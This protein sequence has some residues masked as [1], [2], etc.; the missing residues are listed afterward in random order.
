MIEKTEK[1]KIGGKFRAEFSMGQ[2]H[3]E[4]YHKLLMAADNLA[5]RCHNF[6]SESVIPFYGVLKQ[7]YKNFRP[8]MFET[9]RETFDERFQKVKEEILKRVKQRR[10]TIQSFPI[11]IF[12]LL[13]EIDTDLRD[14]AQVMGLGIEVRKELTS[15]QKF[16]KLM[17]IG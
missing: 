15:S 12:E 10:N 13:D 17:G 6:D 8:I 11:F 4:R 7:I 9:R 3:Y 16:K 14:V 5:I 2:Y 1:P